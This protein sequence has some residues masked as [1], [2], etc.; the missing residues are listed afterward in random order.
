MTNRRQF[1]ER[2]VLGAGSMLF[3]SELLASCTD[4]RIDPTKPPIVG[5][6]DPSKGVNY[7]A[8][9]GRSGFK[10]I[11]QKPTDFGDSTQTVMEWPNRLGPLFKMLTANLQIAESDIGLTSSTGRFQWHVKYLSV[12]VFSG[13]A[14]IYPSSGNL[15]HS[16]VGDMMQ[17][18]SIITDNYSI[19]YGFYDAG[20]GV[21]GLTNQ[22]QFYMYATANQSNWM[23]NLANRDPSVKNAPFN[24]FALPGAHDAGMFDTDIVQTL[25]KEFA[26]RTDL[27]SEL[28]IGLAVLDKIDPNLLIRVVIN[29]AFTQKDTIV[30][31]LNLGIRYFDFRPGYNFNDGI[32]ARGLYHQHNFIPGYSFDAFMQDICQWLQS[33]PSEIVVV[34]LGN[35]GFIDHPSMDAK[36][37]T[38]WNI[39]DSQLT[40]SNI[41]LGNKQDLATSYSD[42][43]QAN[44]RLIVLAQYG[45]KTDSTLPGDP[46]YSIPI[47]DTVK[48]DSYSGAYQTTDVNVILSALNGMNADGQKGSDYTVLQLQGTASGANDLVKADSAATLSGASSPLMSTKAAFDYFTYL[49]LQEK[50]GNLLK[51]QLLVCLNDF[52]DNALTD[53][54]MVLTQQRANG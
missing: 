30:Q 6:L 18:P 31:M 34:C 21:G 10:V 5:D 46:V 12:E 45:F 44:K 27:A 1:L 13:Y 11:F 40:A 9:L 28:G 42:L 24:R 2:S 43:I 8:Y 4:H 17:T 23:G 37:R 36:P 35:S 39:I 48:Y 38:L 26:F 32:H 50:S 41:G 52:A 49:W 3:L 16:T 53:H 51:D 20:P 29:T 22:D 33:N 54:C 19:S 14:E 7:Y 25:L 47:W 15:G